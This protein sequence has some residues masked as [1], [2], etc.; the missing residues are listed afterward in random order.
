MTI[1]CPLLESLYFLFTVVNSEGRTTRWVQQTPERGTF[2][3]VDTVA[4]KMSSLLINAAYFTNLSYKNYSQALG[5]Q[6]Q[7]TRDRKLPL[8]G[9]NVGL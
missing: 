5:V 9:Y 1:N 2:A 3:S 6:I 4:S 8:N 7:R